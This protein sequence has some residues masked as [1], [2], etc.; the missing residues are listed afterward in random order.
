MGKE[1]EGGCKRVCV[2]GGG[3]GGRRRFLCRCFCTFLSFLSSVK[4]A[5]VVPHYNRLKFSNACSYFFLVL[6]RLFSSHDI[7][8]NRCTLLWFQFQPIGAISCT[9]S[10]CHLSKKIRPDVS[11][12]SFS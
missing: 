3:G 2:R 11:C 7:G 1:N 8:I 6:V 4:S 10:Y 12:E 9:V 5:V